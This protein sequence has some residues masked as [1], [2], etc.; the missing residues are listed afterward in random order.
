MKRLTIV[1]LLALGAWLVAHAD[2][3]K[4]D[5]RPKPL[6]VLLI[7]GGCC[8]DYG[9]QK[10]ILKAGIEARIRAEVDIEYNKDKSTKTV[11]SRYESGGLGQ[12][13]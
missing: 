13:V 6:R 4:T 8:H 5:A 12:G 3:P 11:F 9:V 7:A 2:Q 1:P 10:D